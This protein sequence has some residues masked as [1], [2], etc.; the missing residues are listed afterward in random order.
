M[1]LTNI[2]SIEEILLRHPLFGKYIEYLRSNLDKEMIFKL[3]AFKCTK[4]PINF[5][6]L[7]NIGQFKRCQFWM[8]ILLPITCNWKWKNISRKIK[9][10][11]KHRQNVHGSWKDTNG[12]D[13]L[14]WT[15]NKFK[16]SES[17]QGSKSCVKFGCSQKWR[18]IN[19]IL[20]YSIVWRKQKILGKV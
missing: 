15:R 8:W 2:S 4:Q 12:D 19:P 3:I 5:F 17:C 20:K 6:R 11:G 7:S 16:M 1:N 9:G 14:I 13:M 18:K 10:T